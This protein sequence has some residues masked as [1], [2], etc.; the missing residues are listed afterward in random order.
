[1][2]WV[3]VRAVGQS[4]Q[5]LFDPKPRFSQEAKGHLEGDWEFLDRSGWPSAGHVRDF[6]ETWVEHYPAANRSELIARI[7]SGDPTLFDSGVFELMIYALLRSLGCE[8]TVHPDVPEGGGKHPD[9]LARPPTREPVYVEAVLA[10]EYS[11]AD[12]AEENHKNA[13]LVA[14]EKLASPDFFLSVKVEKHTS[15]LPRGA[16]LRHDLAAWLARL[17]ADQVQAGG[18]DQIP[19]YSWEHEGWVVAFRAIPKKPECRGQSG[20]VIGALPGD[21]RFVNTREPIRDAVR[22]KGN[23]YGE[24]PHPLLVAINV[25]A[26]SV[27]EIDE[28][29]ALFGKEEFLYDPGKPTI[30]PMLRRRLDGAW[31]NFD[32]PQYTRVSGAWIFH[33]INLWNVGHRRNTLYVNPWATKSLP[34][35]FTTVTHAA[36]ENNEM[37]VREGRALD[38]ILELPSSWPE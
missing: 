26:L 6:L 38:E 21:A 8:V 14:I 30:E 29:E 33:G 31:I 19:H 4:P 22:S 12:A 35:L 1:M 23:R 24:L 15:R 13:V 2:V 11:R 5:M 28:M 27:D 34:A 7:R 3:M 20:R 25:D 9:F 18:F 16:R 32:G 36:P 17:D 10:S 37:K